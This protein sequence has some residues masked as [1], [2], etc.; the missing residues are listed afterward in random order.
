MGGFVN[1][2]QQLPLLHVMSL[3]PQERVVCCTLLGASLGFKKKEP[4]GKQPY[5]EGKSR[6]VNGQAFW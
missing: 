5:G 1:S 4:K 2:E 6:G 3:G